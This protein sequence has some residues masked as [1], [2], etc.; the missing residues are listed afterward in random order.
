MEFP[1][2]PTPQNVKELQ[3]LIGLLNT[4]QGFIK[5]FSTHTQPL[6]Q[7]TEAVKSFVWSKQ[8]DQVFKGLMSQPQL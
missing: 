5:H 6:N 4:Y 2:W 7:L 8:G 3:H 1:N